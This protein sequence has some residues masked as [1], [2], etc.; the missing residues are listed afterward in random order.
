MDQPVTRAVVVGAGS[1]GARHAT[2]LTSLGLEVAFVSARTD[3]DLASF[4]TVSDAVTQFAPDY[5]V[6]ATDTATH[7]AS[8]SSLADAGYRGPLLVEKPLAIESKLLTPFARV[9]V[10]FNLRFHPVVRRLSELLE[11]VEVY[12][13]EAYAGQHLSTWRPGR[14]VNQQYSAHRSR[15]GGVLRDLS[16]EF[17]YL[18][19]LFGPCVGVFARGGRVADVTVDSDDAWAIVAQYQ[20]APLLTLQ[21]NYLDSTARRRLVITTSMG[22]IA[23]D[24]V[25]GTITSSA[26]EESFVVNRDDTYRA[27]HEAML[28][29]GGV[30]SISEASA[31]DQTVSMVELSSTEQRWLASA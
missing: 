25:A 30:A 14:D 8:A 6:I 13:V 10:G 3:L 29:G 23:A 18:A 15:G 17:D 4:A 9:G 24:L 16:H 22:S 7:A 21:L 2:V 26:G 31:T 5:V 11:G 19:L 1:I 20:N 27:M 28:A 12:T